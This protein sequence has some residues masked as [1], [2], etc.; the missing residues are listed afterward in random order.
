M[1][2]EILFCFSD[3]SCPE[4]PSVEQPELRDPPASIK[5]ICSLETNQQ[6]EH[7]KSFFAYTPRKVCHIMTRHVL[8]Q[9][10]TSAQET[11]PGC[12]LKESHSHCWR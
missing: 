5:E 12:S 7:P 3:T 6:Y 1:K 8:T 10:N 4:T 2:A 11:P 9:R